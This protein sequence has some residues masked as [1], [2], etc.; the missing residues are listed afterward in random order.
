LYL[1]ISAGA[2]HLKAASCFGRVVLGSFDLYPNWAAAET[3]D[4]NRARGQGSL[5]YT[6]FEIVLPKFF[7]FVSP[8][9]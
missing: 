5:Q 2:V 7:G 9:R 4:V 8:K 3:F 1:Q 6:R